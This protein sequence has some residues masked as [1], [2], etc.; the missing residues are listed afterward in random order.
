MPPQRAKDEGYTDRSGDQ[1]EGNRRSVRRRNG[2][3]GRAWVDTQAAI[4]QM[5]K[6]FEDLLVEG[7]SARGAIPQEVLDVGCGTGSTTLAM[8]Q[9]IGPG[10]CS[11]GVDLS[12]P[13]IAAA[14]A[15][16]D[17]EGIAAR[18]IHAD[19]QTRAF[20]PGSFDRII[21][22]FGVMFFEDPIRAFVNLR[23]TARDGADPQCIAWRSPAEDLF[24]TTAER[25]AAPLLPSLPARRPDAPG[26]FAFA[27]RRRSSRF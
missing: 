14:C 15:Q 19:P 2:P 26:Q 27:D 17:R 22:R 23:G 10:D 20:E 16:A 25:A 13:M 18:F 6:P 11:T 7:L 8:A 4:D 21:S 24:M 3:A 9:R 1:P 5:L 12:A